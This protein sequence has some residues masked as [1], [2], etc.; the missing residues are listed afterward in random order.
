MLLPLRLLSK[1]PSRPLFI[2]WALATVTLK[3]CTIPLSLSALICALYP[4]RQF[5][6]FFVKC[7]SESRNF[8]LFLWETDHQWT[9]NPRS[10]SFRTFPS[11]FNLF[12]AVAKI[13]S[14]RLFF[15]KYMKKASLRIPIRDLIPR[16]Y[17][18]KGGKG[19]AV[20]FP[21]PCPHV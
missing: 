7:A 10:F 20:Y 15:S 11:V 17:P 12:S 2:S 13:R 3:S 8:P 6:P 1:V 5:F 4:N 18:T 19:S 9:C 16:R 21:V 14:C